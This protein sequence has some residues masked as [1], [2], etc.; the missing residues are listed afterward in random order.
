MTRIAFLGLGAMG[1]R[2]AARLLAAG[3]DVTVWNRTAGSAA[4]LVA[5]GARAAATPRAAAAGAGIAIAM[6]RDDTAS[7]SAW[8]APET[9]ALA[10][11]SPGALAIDCGM[12][13][14]AA[15]RR[16]HGAA[17]AGGVRFLDAPVAGSRPQAEAGQLIFMAGGD[18]A[19][20]EAARPALLA[21]G[22]AVH[23]AGGP[24]CGASV[25]LAVNVLFA[26]QLALLAEQLA[27]A[28]A[29]GA[30]PARLLDI[31]G[32]TPV[33]GPALRAAG[34][35]M[36]AGN[37]APAFPIDLA[38]KDLALALADAAAAGAALPVTDGVAEAYEA[39]RRR[40]LGAQNITAIGAGGGGPSPGSPAG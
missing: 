40:G 37:H 29:G 27:R 12:L 5:A 36:L 3:H 20:V 28:A 4:P 18:A 2:M 11:L 16:L 31:L 32:A 22:G 24:G 25:K 21:M 19:D 15:M 17:R 35:A 14:P 7:E 10:A 23:H 26:G 6:L 30:D 13:S 34:A 39:A 8:F 33:A 1:S 9:G 38:A